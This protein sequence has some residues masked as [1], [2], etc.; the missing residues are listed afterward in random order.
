MKNHRRKRRKKGKALQVHAKDT[1]G[2]DNEIN[3]LEEEVKEMKLSN[4][5]FNAVCEDHYRLYERTSVREET[6]KEGAN[7]EIVLDNGRGKT[8]RVMKGEPKSTLPPLK[9]RTQRRMQLTFAGRRRA[10]EHSILDTQPVHHRIVTENSENTIVPNFSENR[11]KL[12]S[13]SFVGIYDLD[14]MCKTETN[15]EDKLHS[16]LKSSKQVDGVG[17]RSDE[18]AEEVEEASERTKHYFIQTLTLEGQSPLRR[19]TFFQGKFILPG[20]K[21]NALSTRPRKIFHNEYKTSKRRHKAHREREN[22]LPNI[23][24][25]ENRAP[26]I[27]P[28]SYRGKLRARD[29]SFEQVYLERSIPRLPLIVNGKMSHS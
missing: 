20:I 18:I 22:R 1:S 21:E 29:N 2:E 13:L 23:V 27:S 3:P 9:E 7:F 19:K 8:K 6:R 5:Q 11:K 16:I 17:I 24:Q 26:R 14:E 25:S 15:K 12:A 4:L 28:R 10:C